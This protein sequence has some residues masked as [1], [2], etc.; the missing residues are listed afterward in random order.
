MEKQPP[1]IDVHC[2]L[3]NHQI[4]SIRLMLELLNVLRKNKSREMH[5]ISAKGKISRALNFARIGFSSVGK[6][7][8]KLDNDQRQFI[9][10]PLMFDLEGCM[11]YASTPKKKVIDYES[12]LKEELEQLIIEQ[13][14][15]KEGKELLKII[16]K[17]ARGK[18]KNGDKFSLQETQMLRLKKKY[19]DRIFPFF[20][21]DPRRSELFQPGEGETSVAKITKRLNPEKGFS[22][23]KL[24]TP[25]GYSPADRRLLPLY[26]YC[27]KHQIPITAHCSDSGF[28]TFVSSV[29]V[30]GPVYICGKVDY[31]KKQVNFKHNKLK[32]EE[33]VK[34]RATVLNHPILWA[35]VL[36]MF[37]K[38]KLNLAHFGSQK[39]DDTRFIF[40]LMCDYPNL[41]VDFS[42]ISEKY[43]LQRIY[44]DFY[45]NAPDDVKSRFLYGSDFYL[46]LIFVDSMQRYLQQFKDCFTP[47]EWNA[48]SQHNPRRFLTH[49]YNA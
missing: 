7:L 44:N 10:C 9:L 27:E 16:K 11:R 33:R 40:N 36:K 23:I 46:N 41:Y 34:E 26:A 21:V 49:Q 32:G 35:E 12:S 22:G 19:P 31:D 24:Y 39:E 2:H 38:L 45:K 43:L 28:A 48:I 42:C 14:L 20:F 1:L 3:F 15:G 4:L 13:D 30:E 18:K 37:P 47:D 17:E 8:S 29:D 6:I 5:L 25:N